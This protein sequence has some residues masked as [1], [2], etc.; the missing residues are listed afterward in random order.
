MYYVVLLS[1][2]QLMTSVESCLLL[3]AFS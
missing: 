2:V 1:N 3:V